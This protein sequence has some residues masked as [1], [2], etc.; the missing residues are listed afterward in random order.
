MTS[1]GEVSMWGTAHTSEL[2]LLFETRMTTT[3]D[4]QREFAPFNR[5]SLLIGSQSDTNDDYDR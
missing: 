1:R 5:F 4:D 3:K 2:W